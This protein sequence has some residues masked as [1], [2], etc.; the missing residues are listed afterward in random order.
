MI[1]IAIPVP[2]AIGLAFLV[3]YAV[4]GLHALFTIPA[5]PP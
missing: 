5:P 1:E 4:G 3:G 2:V